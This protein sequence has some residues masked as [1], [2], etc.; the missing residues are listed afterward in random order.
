M[1][2]DR[3]LT[4]KKPIE[5]TPW[6]NVYRPAII[7]TLVISSIIGIA[8]AVE[9]QDP[10]STFKRTFAPLSECLSDTPF[11]PNKTDAPASIV[12]DERDGY[13]GLLVIPEAPNYT[14][15]SLLTFRV[16]DGDGFLVPPTFA[17]TD[18]ATGSYVSGLPGCPALPQY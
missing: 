5:N 7:G 3:F 8:A 16:L 6:N 18:A 10:E 1:N 11:D 4:S 2:I 13:T 12:V 17:Q 9:R 14:E 15:P